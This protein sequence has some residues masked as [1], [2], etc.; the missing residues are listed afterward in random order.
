M[1]SYAP[2]AVEDEEGGAGG[3]RRRF[4]SGHRSHAPRACF[5]LDADGPHVE[6]EAASVKELV[7]VRCPCDRAVQPLVAPVVGRVALVTSELGHASERLLV[8]RYRARTFGTGA[9]HLDRH[10]WRHGLRRWQQRCCR[11]DRS[12]RKHD[13][14]QGGDHDGG[15]ARR[16]RTDSDAR[17]DTHGRLLQQG[18]PS[19]TTAAAARGSDDSGKQ[20]VGR[21]EWGGLLEEL[22][23]LALEDAI[24]VHAGRSCASTRVASGSSRMERRRVA[25]P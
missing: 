17:R 23:H 11:D 4:H 6:A 22:D 13:Q 21:P 25:R 8:G 3:P 2:L 16:R 14:Q 9:G 20:V 24:V 12:G 1:P 5:V 19:R 18:E 15:E 7:L 10:Q